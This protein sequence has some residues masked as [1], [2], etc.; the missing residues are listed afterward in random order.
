MNALERELTTAKAEAAMWKANHDNQVKLK[1]IIMSRPDLGDRAPRVIAFMAELA[2]A[3]AECERLTRELGKAFTKAEAD[4]AELARLRA[5]NSRLR[6][7]LDSSRK[8]K[9]SV[10]RRLEAHLRHAKQP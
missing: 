3:K 6:V 9:E 7:D 10:S 4:A 8:D 1:S 5:E 2:A